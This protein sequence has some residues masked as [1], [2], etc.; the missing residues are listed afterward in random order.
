MQ[1]LQIVIDITV[2]LES[3]VVTSFVTCLCFTTVCQPDMTVLRVPARHRYAKNRTHHASVTVT[4]LA[5]C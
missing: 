5:A 2:N 3:S 1:C 4:A